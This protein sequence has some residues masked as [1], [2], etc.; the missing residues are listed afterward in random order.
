MPKARVTAATPN[1]QERGQEFAVG[2]RA[3]PFAEGAANLANFAG[4]VVAVF[5][6]IGMV[7]V[8]FPSGVKRYPVED[9]QRFDTENHVQT[10]DEKHTTVPAGEGTVGVSS[11][12]AVQASVRRVAELWVKRALYWAAADRK[13]KATAQ[14]CT[15]KAYTCPKCKA[16]QL[17][18]AIYKRVEGQSEKLYGCPEC[19]FL[20]KRDDI[21]EES[22]LEGGL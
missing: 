19:L 20:I 6:A 7:D 10:P 13:Y 9:L 4:T 2:D 5:P 17:R 1:Y 11:G 22:V 12:P 16:A 21:F 14:E 15:S 8:E 18:K 3:V